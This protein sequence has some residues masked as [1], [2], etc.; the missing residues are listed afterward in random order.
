MQDRFTEAYD[1]PRALRQLLGDTNIRNALCTPFAAVEVIEL[2]LA[3][4]DLAQVE[5]RR[6]RAGKDA[7]TGKAPPEE[8]PALDKLAAALDEGRGL[9]RQR[10][11]RAQEGRRALRSWSRAAA[12]LQPQAD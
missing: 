10:S 4:S 12:W 3:L 2:E 7:K 1:H 11:A 8:I 9:S 5:K 6:E